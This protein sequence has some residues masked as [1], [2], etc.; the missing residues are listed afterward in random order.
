MLA[1]LSCF[2]LFLYSASRVFCFP[3]FFLPT[4]LP[5]LLLLPRSGGQRG[6]RGADPSWRA[7]ALGGHPRRSRGRGLRLRPGPLLGRPRLGGRLGLGLDS[8]VA[9]L[10]SRGAC[11]RRDVVRDDRVDAGLLLRRVSARVVVRSAPR[12]QPQ[13]ARVR[14][15]D[16]ARE[17][18][19]HRRRLGDDALQVGARRELDGRGQRAH[20]RVLEGLGAGVGQEEDREARLL[21]REEGGAVWV[22]RREDHLSAPSLLEHDAEHGVAVFVPGQEAH[23]AEGG[24][25][26]GR[27]VLDLDVEAEPGRRGAEAL[28]ER[29]D[30]VGDAPGGLGRGGV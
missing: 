10:F 26:G 9:R 27:R 21:Q 18:R 17:P 7:P 15:G 30:A 25:V 19:Q 23:A 5:L 6:K 14:R 20:P 22:E 1:W 2:L 13:P 11:V 29:G 16:G 8:R 12:E 24:R 3:L 4:S 28:A